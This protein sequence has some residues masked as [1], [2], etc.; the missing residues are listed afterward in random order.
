MGDDVPVITD[1]KALEPS[2]DPIARAGVNLAGIARWAA[3]QWPDRPALE[4]ENGEHLTFGELAARVAGLAEQLQHRRVRAGDIVAV[5]LDNCSTFPLLTLAAAHLG[6]S[7]VPLNPGFTD[8]ELDHILGLTKPTHL[9]GLAEYCGA[10]HGTLTAHGVVIVPFQ[11]AVPDTEPPLE[12]ADAGYDQLG[13]ADYLD[14]RVRFGLT[15][16]STGVPKAVTKTQRQWLLDGRAIA[17]LMDL[18]P[19]DRVLSAQPLYY[20]DPFMILMACLQSG[21]TAVFLSRFRSQTFMENV[22]GRAITKFMT[23][24]AM[25]AMLMNTPA[26]ASDSGHRAVAAWSVGIP[27]HLHQGLEERFGVPWLELYGTSETGVIMAQVQSDARAIGDGWLG[28]PMPGQKIRLV[29]DNGET[30]NGDG[31]GMLEVRGPTVT[32]EYYRRPDATAESFLPG[33]WYRPGDVMERRGT[34]YR[35]LNRRKDIVRRAG[36]NISCQE[37]EAVLRAQEGV[38]DAAVIPRPDPVRGEEVW[39]FV[40]LTEMPSDTD[41]ARQRAEIMV[42]SARGSLARHKLPRFVSFVEKFERTPSERIVKRRLAA[43]GDSIPTWDLGERR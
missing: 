12:P 30:I 1:A 33:G 18:G 25:P 35:Y 6:A 38:V 11:T 32:R 4:T 19:N 24:G 15:S 14:E 16:G 39:A 28:H 9:V 42:S 23:I 8:A 27:R 7:V 20:G 10:H 43:I 31:I 17:T 40:L 26:S 21:A 34:Q 5:C 36:E 37:V 2:I 29:D 3:R 22:A 41:T 13:S